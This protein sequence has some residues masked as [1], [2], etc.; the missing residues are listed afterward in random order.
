M[1]FCDRIRRELMDNMGSKSFTIVGGD[2][3][4][5]I[6]VL[7]WIKECVAEQSIVKFKE[8][9]KHRDATSNRNHFIT[10]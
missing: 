3:S 7:R 10:L 5:H 2:L 6:E 8:V 4:S 9:R 1:I